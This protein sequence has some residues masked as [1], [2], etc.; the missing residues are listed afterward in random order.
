MKSKIF[1][2]LAILALV[3]T[4]FAFA[5][6]G[7]GDDDDNGDRDRPLSVTFESTCEGNIVTVTSGGDA[8]PGA[9]VTV[10]DTSPSGGILVSGDTDSNGQVMFDGCSMT[11]NIFVSKKGYESESL[12]RSLVDCGQCEEE[13]RHLECV[14]SACVAVLGAGENECATDADCVE[15][16]PEEPEPEPECTSDD[17]CADTQYCDIPVGAGGGDCADVTGDCGYA[18][19]HAWV[20]YECG[21][22]PGCA[23]CPAGMFCVEHECVAGDVECPATA[24]VGDEESCEA[25]TDGDVCANCDYE[26]TDPSGNKLTGKTDANGNFYIP[27]NMQGEYTVVLL[28]EDGTPI[29]SIVVN[30]LP[31]PAVEEPGEPT[32]VTDGGDLSLFFI[33]LVVLLLLLLFWWLIRRGGKRRR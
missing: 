28:A 29:K 3:M 31:K 2:I 12:T 7:Y 1:V 25:S 24:F 32:V 10:V 23:S 19:A 15:A 8:L 13:E 20:Q 6:Y 22:E 33:I 4:P 27:F 14:N 21:D 18:A 26:V 9:R 11:V 5:Q 30:A 17:D 16:P